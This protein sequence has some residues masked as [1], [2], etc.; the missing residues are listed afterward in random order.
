MRTATK[1][2]LVSVERYLADELISAVKHEYLGGVVYAM[3]GARNAHNLI[4]TNALVALANRLRGRPCR[5][6]NSD[7]KIRVHLPGHVRFYYPDASVICRSNPPA[8]SFQDQPAAVVE[9]L[10][11]RTRRLD[12]GEKKE[13]YLTIP[14]L[15]FYILI[16]QEMPA[17]IL[18]SRT[19]QG[20]LRE[21]YQGL[22]AILPLRSL[23]IDLPLAEIF[24]GV[25][26]IPEAEDEG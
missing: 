8:E 15:D 3:A 14:S 12:E 19:E 1:L 25:E 11:Q 20:F 17:V 26:F 9:V 22:E 18:F 16:E 5:A 24:E 13:A 21:V 7:T 10:S 23:G 4:A 2:N 6:F